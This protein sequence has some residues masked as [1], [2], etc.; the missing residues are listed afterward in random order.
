MRWE[1]VSRRA[2]LTASSSSTSRRLVIG[3]E[4][5]VKIVEEGSIGR[6]RNRD[7][8][9][10]LIVPKVLGILN[11]RGQKLRGSGA[12][13]LQLNKTIVLSASSIDAHRLMMSVYDGPGSEIVKAFSLDVTDFPSAMDPDFY[14]YRGGRVAVLSWCRGKWEDAIMVK[15]IPSLSISEALRQGPTGRNSPA[16]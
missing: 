1:A 16:T 6:I 11:A 14:R 10:E 4:A 12:C 2:L 13:S 8:V 3:M 9:L 5:I 7:S 15:K